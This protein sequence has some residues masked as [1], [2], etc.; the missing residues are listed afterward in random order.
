MSD[1]SDITRA[2][3]KFRDARDWA[4]FH[5]PKD[6]AA[7][8][9]IEA[10]ELL[11]LFLWKDAEDADRG[12]VGEELA[13]VISYALLLAHHYGLDVQEIVSAKIRA[14]EE[15]YPVEKARGSARKYD[16]L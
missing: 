6:L 12:K 10:A 7:A 13:D 15:R 8:L 2:L 3:V 4:Q 9:S 11:E 16:E 5:N 14:N 1:V